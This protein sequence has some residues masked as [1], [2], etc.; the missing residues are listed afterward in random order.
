MH[1][2]QIYQ[3]DKLQYLKKIIHENWVNWNAPEVLHMVLS[4]KGQIGFQLYTTS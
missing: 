2:S 4:P 3:P 1:L